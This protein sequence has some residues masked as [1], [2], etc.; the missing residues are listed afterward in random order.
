MERSRFLKELFDSGGLLQPL[1]WGPGEAFRFLEDAALFETEGLVV[2]MPAWGGARR[3]ASAE[4]RVTV[5]KRK[6]GAVGLD[7]LLDFSV[8]VA[9]GDHTLLAK[10]IEALIAQGAA[11]PRESER[12]RDDSARRLRSEVRLQDEMNRACSAAYLRRVR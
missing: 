11:D 6:P 3:P 1:L 4:V 9:L 5:G 12:R 2:K 10:E 8:D 7:A